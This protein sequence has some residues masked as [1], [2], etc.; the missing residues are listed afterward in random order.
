MV[1]Q[2]ARRC[3]DTPMIMIVSPLSRASMQVAPA[4]QPVSTAAVGTTTSL[5][6]TVTLSAAALAPAKA[7]PT[8]SH[9]DGHAVMLKRLFE[10]D[11]SAV[12]PKFDISTLDWA[13]VAGDKVYNFLNRDDRE[14]V[15][16]AY[17]QADAIG[18]DP[19][20]VDNLAFDLG[21]YRMNV[22]TGANR[23]TTGVLFMPDGRPFIDVFKPK[24]EAV[25]RDMLSL[26][27]MDDTTIDHGFLQVA[28]D[29]GLGGSEHAVDFGALRKLVLVFS[30]NHSDGGRNPDVSFAARDARVAL[31]EAVAAMAP[32]ATK[33][34]PGAPNGIDGKALMMSRLFGTG[35]SG[36]AV[37]HPLASFLTDDDKDMLGDMYALA[38]ANGADLSQLDKLSES[39][40]ALRQAEGLMKQQNAAGSTLALLFDASELHGKSALDGHH[41]SKIVPTLADN[42]E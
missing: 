35:E 31:A 39:L 13:K 9:T 23:D 22:N 37:K 4:P 40:G 20:E 6:D 21:Y 12:E 26:K 42:P 19:H 41:D 29:P 16:K 28:L 32:V 15:E 8:V 33:T 10:L 18:V 25:I 27:A 30:P 14:M 36:G 38:K 2:L 5:R 24:D 1:L 11:D 17:E 34:P 3:S 7:Q